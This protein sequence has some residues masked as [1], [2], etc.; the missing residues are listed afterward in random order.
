[1]VIE[2]VSAV[3]FGGNV[4]SGAEFNLSRGSTIGD[5]QRFDGF[6]DSAKMPD[7]TAFHNALFRE[8]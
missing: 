7:I 8:Q 4:E 2:N 5:A 6:Q 3:R 1:M